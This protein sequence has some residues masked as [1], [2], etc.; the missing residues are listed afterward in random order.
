MNVVFRR[1]QNNDILEINEIE[2][3]LFDDAWSK[4]IFLHE[5][6]NTSFSFPYLLILKDTIVGYCVCWYY[7]NELQIGNFAI[8]NEFQ[9]KGLGKLLMEKIFELFPN[10]NQAF[11]EVNVSNNAAVSLYLKFG[12]KNV[13]VPK[14][15]SRPNAVGGSSYLV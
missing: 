2:N 5:I 4:A 7:Q 11:L 3:D 15:R 10:Y 12:F 6:K 13:V 1:M 14:G 9:G 8:K